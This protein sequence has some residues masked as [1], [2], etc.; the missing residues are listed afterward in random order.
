MVFPFRKTAMTRTK[1]ST[2]TFN[3]AFTL[4]GV[5][6]SFPAG[7]YE[8]VMDEELIEGLSFSAYRRVAS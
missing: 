7:A 2:L 6:R 3:R 5:D 8:L 4:E 1:R